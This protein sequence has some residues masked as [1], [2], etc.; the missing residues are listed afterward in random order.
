RVGVRMVEAP[1]KLLAELPVAHP[2]EALGHGQCGKVPPM[3]D[4]VE[5]RRAAPPVERPHEGLRAE[6]RVD[7]GP[8]LAGGG[9]KTRLVLPALAVAW[10]QAHTLPDDGQARAEGQLDAALAV[11]RGV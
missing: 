10:P 2:G 4:P 6:H 3:E 11:G 8:P 5:D 7:R 1:A 9:K